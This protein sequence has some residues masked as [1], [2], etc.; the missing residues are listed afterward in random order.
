MNS[1]VELICRNEN[2]L[3]IEDEPH[4]SQDYCS[5]DHPEGVPDIRVALR[6]PSEERSD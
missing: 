4:R 3:E 2:W 5:I 6:S 1:P